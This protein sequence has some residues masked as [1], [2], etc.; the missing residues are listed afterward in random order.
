MIYTA[1]ILFILA[2]ILTIS[3]KL[4]KFN[5][6]KVKINLTYIDKHKKE[7]EK[8]KKIRQI[9]QILITINAIRYHPLFELTYTC[10]SKIYTFNYNKIYHGI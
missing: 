7:K 2:L 6:K 3:I 9:R 8:T 5:K 1:L 10:K 4:I